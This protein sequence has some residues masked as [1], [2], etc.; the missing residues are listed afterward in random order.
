MSKKV[1]RREVFSTI[2][3]W[4]S[5]DVLELCGGDVALANAVHEVAVKEV[6]KAARPS[7]SAPSQ[8]SRENAKLWREVV[9]PYMGST[10][11]AT[12]RDVAESCALPCGANGR[13][14]VQ[15][16]IAVLNV[17]LREGAITLADAK[18]DGGKVYTLAGY[19]LPTEDEG[20]ASL[21]W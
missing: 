2:A 15:K 9:A 18:R 7:V 8:A 20:T 19:E 10:K 16:A 14:S 17:G 21:D 12:A 4:P 1:T 13:V 6:A 5:A 11:A 3:E